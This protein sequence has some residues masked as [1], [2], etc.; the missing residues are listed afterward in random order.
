MQ[1]KTILIKVNK[2]LFWVNKKGADLMACPLVLR[3]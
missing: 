2:N 3:S 1:I